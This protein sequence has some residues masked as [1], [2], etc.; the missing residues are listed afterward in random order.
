MECIKN[1]RYTSYVG[2]TPI[3]FSSNKVAFIKD[4][5]SSV[6]RCRK[7]SDKGGTHFEKLEKNVDLCYE[8]SLD[9]EYDVKSIRKRVIN[10]HYGLNK[11]LIKF[12]NRHPNCTYSCRDELKLELY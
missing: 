1:Q 10:G 4:C 9:D 2:L 8:G 12:I 5:D 3:T 7:N 11:H 6:I